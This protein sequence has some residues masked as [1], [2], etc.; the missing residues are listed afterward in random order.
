MM[1]S[2]DLGPYRPNPTGD[3]DPAKGYRYLDIVNYSGASY[4]CCNLDTIDGTACIGVLPEG[5]PASP[6]YWMC[7]AH[8]GDKGDSPNVYTPYGV[9]LDGKWDFSQTDKIFIPID[10]IGDGIEITN[11]YDGCCGIII[12]RKDLELPLN[13]M[14]SID[15]NFVGLST[16]DDYYFYTFTYCNLGGTAEYKFIWHRSVVTKP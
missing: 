1:A 15:Y 2:Y 12:T 13:S 5:E 3:Y 8:R 7:L 6:N 16:A 4:I 9:V 11:V 10:S 14:K